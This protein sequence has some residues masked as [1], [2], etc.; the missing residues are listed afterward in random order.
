MRSLAAVEPSDLAW[1]L[2]AEAVAA[3]P[4]PVTR[5]DRR[6]ESLSLDDASVDAVLVTFSL[7]TVQD[8][9]AVL[10][11]ARRVL[12]PGG[13]LHFLEHGLSRM[14]RCSAGS[15]GSTHCRDVSRVVA[16]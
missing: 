14:R 4:V 16:T 7:C 2:A 10:R 12:R 5:T 9:A 1:E 11:Q 8:P 13:R 3:S 6:A 15:A